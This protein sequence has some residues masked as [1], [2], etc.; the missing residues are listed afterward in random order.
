M[1][2]EL[3]AVFI[4]FLSFILSIISIV[5]AYKQRIDSLMPDVEII[6]L[7]AKTSLL[8]PKEMPN[9]PITSIDLNDPSDPTIIVV[10]QDADTKSNI[11][12]IIQEIEIEFTL[13]NNSSKKAIGHINIIDIEKKEIFVNGLSERK[14]NFKKRLENISFEMAKEAIAEKKELFYAFTLKGVASETFDE[15]NGRFYDVPYKEDKTS[16]CEKVKYQNNRR[17][18]YKFLRNKYLPI[19]G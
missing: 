16:K 6:D 13:K 5:M 4:A 1:E 3:I 8:L 2:I 11:D 9:L 10:N 17:R 14:L 7:R 15:N 19:Q 18:K 12:E